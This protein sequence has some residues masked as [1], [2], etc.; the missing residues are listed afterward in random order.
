MNQPA[1][2]YCPDCGEKAFHPIARKKLVCSVC[3]FQFYRNAA[4]AV[5][6]VLLFENEI[7]VGRRGRNPCKGQL[8]L[9]G[10][11][12]DPGESL[13]AA[14]F[15]ELEEE[16]G[17]H[18]SEASYV[19]SGSNRYHFANVDYDTSDAFFEI[20]F[21]QRPAVKAMDDLDEAVWLTLNELQLDQFAFA[22]QQ[23]LL[24]Q[25]YLS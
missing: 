10:G 19:C 12:V 3:E 16:L 23:Q 6:A 2:L 8:D 5:A 21:N 18:V 1:A 22:S 4:S 9:P 14:L 20:R 13:E 17:L 7:L 25:H 11:F 15:R 24:K